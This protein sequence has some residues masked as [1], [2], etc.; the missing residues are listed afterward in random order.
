MIE[1]GQVCVYVGKD[2]NF[3]NMKCIVCSILDNIAEVIFSDEILGKV[4]TLVRINDL[5]GIE[6]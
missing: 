1:T 3:R 6:T 2:L 5:L 4:V